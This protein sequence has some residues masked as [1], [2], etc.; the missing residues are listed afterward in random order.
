MENKTFKDA[1]VIAY[2]NEKFIPIK[3]NA[4]REPKTS[5]MFRVRALPDN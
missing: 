5:Q 4:D 1:T 2:R 3:V